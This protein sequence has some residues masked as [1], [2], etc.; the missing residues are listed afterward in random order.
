MMNREES[1]KKWSVSFHEKPFH[2]SVT[3]YG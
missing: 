1:W 3:A 2:P